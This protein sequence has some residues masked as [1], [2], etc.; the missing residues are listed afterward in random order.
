MDT[1]STKVEELDLQPNNQTL[2][3][4]DW[5]VLR[6]STSETMFEVLNTVA[7]KRFRWEK[8][9]S[10]RFSEEETKKIFGFNN[11]MIR[12]CN[13]KCLSSP[14]CTF[15]L[16]IKFDLSLPKYIF[17]IK[18]LKH[19]GHEV[20]L[21]PNKRRFRCDLKENELKLLRY[22]TLAYT[23]LA[24]VEVALHREFPGVHFDSSLVKREVKRLKTEGRNSEDTCV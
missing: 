14:T 4:D 23:S 8:A 12:R 24:N 19:S 11:R 22:L 17:Q 5:T 9:S 21:D 20:K 13:F 18:N 15:E 1:N 10:H 16:N 3:N 6:G 2:P 7:A